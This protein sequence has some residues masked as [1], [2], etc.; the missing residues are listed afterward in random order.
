MQ[1][2]QQETLDLLEKSGRDGWTLRLMTE[3]RKGGW[4]PPLRRQTQP[5]TNKPLYVWDE[6]DI[7]QIVEVYDWWR[8]CDGDRATLTLALWLQGYEVPLDLLRRLYLGIIE[9]Y[10]QRLTRG[11]TDPDDVL[12][13]VSKI[14]V[15]LSR[16]LRYSPRLAAQR[17]KL[18]I[19]QM[20]L[21]TETVLGALAV[22][23]EELT[24]ETFHSFLLAAGEPLDPSTDYEEEFEEFFAT[25]Q[26]VAA[27]LQDILSLPNLREV[28]QTATPE[29]W[30][31]AREDYL[32]LCQLCSEFWELAISA[33]TPSLPE[34]L[35]TNWKLRGACW[36]M[37][38][39]LSTRC[40]GYGQWID[41]A[42]AK[43]HEGL[44]DP[45]IQAQVFSKEG[46][47]RTI[48]AGTDDIEQPELSA[49]GF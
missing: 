33:G 11:K 18:S 14:V 36:L 2:T 39:F 31:Q 15:V 48:E 25:P 5:G 23:S 6:E 19:E 21:I 4:L 12:D 41:M 40:R 38:P 20:E 9:G 35:F 29:Q 34:A 10:L 27:V 44:A 24:A 32:S 42:F 26:H 49:T 13:E 30:E 45:S 1:L 22:P 46:A 3:L 8:Y 16:K 7:E 28:V 17:K 43:I 47:G 37:V